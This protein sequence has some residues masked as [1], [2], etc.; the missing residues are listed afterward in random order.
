M[1]GIERGGPRPADEPPRRGR[2]AAVNIGFDALAIAAQA[3]TMR[4]STGLADVAARQ[5]HADGA[6]ILYGR[7]DEDLELPYQPFAEALGHFVTHYDL[8]QLQAHLGAHGPEL[9]RS[10]VRHQDALGPG[11]ELEGRHTAWPIPA[12]VDDVTLTSLHSSG[13]AHAQPLLPQAHRVQDVVGVLLGR[14]ALVLGMLV[15]WLGWSVE[16]P[17]LAP[18]HTSGWQWAVG[19][20]LIAIGEAIRL[21]G[22]AAAGTV[23]R[24]RSR[25]VQRLVTYGIFSWVRNPLY[26]GNILILAGLFLIWNSRWMYLIGIPFFLL[27]YV[28]IVLRTPPDLR[29]HRGPAHRFEGRRDG[30]G[31]NEAQLIGIGRRIV[32]LDAAQAV[33]AFGRRARD[34]RLD[35]PSQWARACT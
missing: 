30:A 3:G 24:R 10:C 1:L 16:A 26:V 22:V 4:I 11:F 18:G 7:C 5:A 20:V 28:A 27:G 14:L 2:W 29:R 31:P 6:R 25:N 34:V 8:A 13:A 23:T 9:A 35:P 15:G 12:R 33:D 17:V 32:R 19:G 21:A